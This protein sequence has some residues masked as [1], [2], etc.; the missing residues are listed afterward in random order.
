MFSNL[1]YFSRAIE[2]N[3]NGF[4][5]RCF[6]DKDLYSATGHGGHCLECRGNRD[7]PNCE[8][9][10]P[11]YFQPSGNSICYPCNCHETGS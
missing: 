4:S 8:R 7:G 3:C 5:E 9:C 10:R 1:F 2:C 6:F 11:Y